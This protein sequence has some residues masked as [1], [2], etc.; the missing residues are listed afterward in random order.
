MN[1]TT[2]FSVDKSLKDFI[3][4][5][6]KEITLTIKQEHYGIITTL[7]VVVSLGTCTWGVSES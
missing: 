2:Y 4:R 7:T 1:Q 6:D 5:N 3:F